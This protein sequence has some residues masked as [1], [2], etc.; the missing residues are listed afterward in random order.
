MSSLAWTILFA[1]A[2]VAS[3]ATRA[4][5]AARQVRH[6][7][8]H[9]GEVPAAFRAARLARRAPAGR[10]LHPRQ[11]APGPLADGR[12][13]P[14]SCS[15]GRCSAGSTRS[16][17][18][19]ATRSRR[20]SARSP[21]RSRSSPRSSPIGAVLELPF[22]WYATFRL[23]QRFGFNR[24]DLARSGSPTSPRGS[25]LGV[26]HRPAAARRW[27][28]G[29]WRPPARSGGS[30]PGPR[31]MAFSCRRAGGRIRR[32]IAPLFNRFEPLNDDAA[33]S[34]AS[35][36]L[37]PRA[38]SPRKGLF[39]MDGSRR[40][41]HANA[42]FTGFGAAKRVVFFDTLLARLGAGE[43]EA[44]LAHE[45]GHF[46]LRHISKRMLGDARDQPR[47][48]SPCSAGSSTQPWFYTGLGVTPNLALPQRRARAAAVP[49]REPGVRR[50][51]R[52]RSSPGWSRRDEFEADAFA[53]DPRRRPASSRRPCSSCTRTTPSTLTPDP[54]YARFYY[55]HPPAVERLAALAPRTSPPSRHDRL[56]RADSAR[57][58]PRA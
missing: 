45:L 16:T 48:A 20:A 33:A 56:P 11:D 10:R 44:V 13:A 24:I 12:P 9:R 30:G 6:V 1:T 37:M 25:L 58:A 35:Q 8:R 17:S 52:R 55:S 39:V 46:K 27:C 15:A 3:L 31:W 38:A 51:R 34:R 49:A 7:A 4:W 23:E 18:R 32:V 21:T 26:R 2:L 36:A 19:C 22:D 53:V 50:V 41:A 54:V 42:Y 40:S 43:V 5:L 47:V 57:R 14:P 29:S 28:S